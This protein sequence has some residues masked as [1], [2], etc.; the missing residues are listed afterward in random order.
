MSYPHPYALGVKT[1]ESSG[2]HSRCLNRALVG[3]RQSY[4][5]PR[6]VPVLG[7]L[8]FTTLPRYP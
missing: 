2:F 6:N 8:P 3:R 5:I 4:G 1:R 7:S